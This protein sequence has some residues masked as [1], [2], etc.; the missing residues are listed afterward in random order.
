[1]IVASIIKKTIKNKQYYYYVESARVNGKP[2]YVN[3]VYLGSAE[4][5]L[6]KVATL[7]PSEALYSEIES[8]ADVCLL[9]DLAERLSVIETLNECFPKRNQGVSVGVYALIAAINRAVAPMAKVNIEIWYG[10]TVLRSLMPVPKGGLACQ[11]FWDNMG[12]ISEGQIDTFEEV[13]LEEILRRYPIRASRLI[14]D[15]TNFCN[16]SI[17]RGKSNSTQS[18]LVNL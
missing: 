8:F 6:R 16:C 1:M 5:V 18:N 3:Q 17:N 13:F 10:K 15:A 7:K 14:Y 11:R 4:A 9:Y 2:K 12:L